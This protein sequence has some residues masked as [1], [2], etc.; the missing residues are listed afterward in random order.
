MLKRAFKC[1]LIKL[2]AGPNVDEAIS[3][4]KDVEI[5]FFISQVPCGVVDRF[6]GSTVSP[7]CKGT[8]RKPG[9]G[10]SSVKCSCVD[11][12]CKWANLGLQGRRLYN[13]LGK[14]PFN[15]LVIGNCVEE[16]E[17]N[18]HQLEERIACD[19]RPPGQSDA[20][21]SKRLKRMPLSIYFCPSFKHDELT[22]SNS[23]KAFQLSMVAWIDDEKSN[24]LIVEKLVDGRKQGTSATNYNAS[25]SNLLAISDFRINLQLDQIK[26]P[27]DSEE[28]TSHWQNLLN[29]QR[30]SGWSDIKFA[31]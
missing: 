3:Y 18:Q 26:C 16:C 4:L 20:Q 5:I 17:F 1:R 21:S 15:S 10:E 6:A 24:S 22:R 7:D 30:F 2:L 27:I 8:R 9:K 23:K 25:N 19:L 12:L 31:K 13:L 11:K 14:L 29:T 28:Y